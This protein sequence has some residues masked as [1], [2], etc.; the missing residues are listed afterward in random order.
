MT[1]PQ[2]V[3]AALD[4]TTRG[5][6]VFPVYE[7]R[8]GRCA[9]PGAC[10]SNAGKHPRTMNGFKDATTNEAAIRSWWAQWPR[11][12]VAIATGTRSGLGVLDVDP[13]HS[14]DETL[15]QLIRQHGELPATVEAQT[16]GR[17]RHVVFVTSAPLASRIRLLPGLDWKAEGGYIVAPPSLHAS[18]RR[19]EWLIG[20]G[21]DEIALAPLPSWLLTLV[22]APL[23]GAA[24]PGRLRHD[25][26]PLVIV[27]GQR[28][29]LL[30]RIGCALR[31]YGVGDQAL[32]V[33]LLAINT[34]HCQPPLD[35]REVREIAENAARYRPGRTSSETS[36]GPAHPRELE[37]EVA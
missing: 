37:I 28:N 13:R 4:Y 21:P 36:G 8:D 12:N 32:V 34:R 30:F 20:Y 16:G 10:G 15:A 17:G 26:T 31:R 2:P 29:D 7:I 35:D 14:G 24:G 3:E 1:V 25:G 19:Y 18:G 22:T 5:W 33:C 6:P 23:G 11:A 9:C 27:R